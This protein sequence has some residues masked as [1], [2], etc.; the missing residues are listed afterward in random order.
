[1]IQVAQCWD[2]GVLNDIPVAE[3][4]RKY[5]AKATFN[6]NPGLHLKSRRIT[7]GWT[8]R[9]GYCPG[10]LAWSEV[11][12]VYEGFE[13]ASHTMNHCNAG[14]VD[15]R[16]FLEQSL[17]ARNVLEDRF[18]KP[19]PGFAWPCGRYTPE[20]MQLLREAGFAYARSTE[21]VAQVLPCADPMAFHSNCHFM[22]PQ[23]WSIFEAARACGVF[24]FWGHSYEMMEDEKLWQQYEDKLQRF[25]ADP[26]IEWVNVVDL[27]AER[28]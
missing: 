17:G 18:G 25:A 22:N 3:L 1:M 11:N 14:E 16:V 8:Y 24:Y 15:D 13:V 7:E 5:G 21:N 23:F 28:K 2:D 12:S 20:T 19:C 4:C 6:L 27:V 26:D 10:R 9:D